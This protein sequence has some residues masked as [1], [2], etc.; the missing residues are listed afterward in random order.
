M[1]SLTEKTNISF[2]FLKQPRNKTEEF[3][4]IIKK[5]KVSYSD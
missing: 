4:A 2:L 1:I 3:A 5:T